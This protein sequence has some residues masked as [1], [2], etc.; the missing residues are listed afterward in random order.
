LFIQHGIRVMQWIEDN[1]KL[2]VEAIEEAAGQDIVG[3]K[4]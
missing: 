4:E 3:S 2:L 1:E